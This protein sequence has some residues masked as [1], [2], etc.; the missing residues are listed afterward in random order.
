MNRWNLEVRY[1]LDDAISR[2]TETLFNIAVANHQKFPL[3][4]KISEE[5]CLELQAVTLNVFAKYIDLD[6]I[7]VFFFFSRVKH[8]QSSLVKSIIKQKKQSLLN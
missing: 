3:I 4:K 5:E 1:Q 7:K 6:P 8:I 2:M